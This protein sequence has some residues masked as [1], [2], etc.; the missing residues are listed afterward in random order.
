MK[1]KINELIINLR[2]SHFNPVCYRSWKLWAMFV[3]VIQQDTLQVLKP[4]SESNLVVNTKDVSLIVT[5]QKTFV[6]Q[7]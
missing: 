5:S 3:E 4:K 7:I 2:H 6:H 1:E